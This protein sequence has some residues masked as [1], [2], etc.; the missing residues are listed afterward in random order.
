ML[1]IPTGVYFI[2]FKILFIYLREREEKQQE[3]GEE[4]EREGKA[5]PPPSREPDLE[6]DARL[7]PRTPK[8]MTQAKVRCLTN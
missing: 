6:P 4:A 3:S 7:D 1:I 2:F 8:I 5:D